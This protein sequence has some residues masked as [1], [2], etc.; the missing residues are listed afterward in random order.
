MSA[1]RLSRTSLSKPSLL[2][3]KR[4]EEERE[5]PVRYSVSIDSEQ[6]GVFLQ[7]LLSY[8]QK[9]LLGNEHMMW[10]ERVQHPRQ[11]DSSSSKLGRM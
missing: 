10:R 8:L 9:H 11:V 3:R 7:E 6:I 5:E 1:M 2:S 4:L